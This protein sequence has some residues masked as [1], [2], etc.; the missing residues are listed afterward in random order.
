MS[1]KCIEQII[2]ANLTHIEACIR[3]K[4]WVWV[5]FTAIELFSLIS[6]QCIRKLILCLV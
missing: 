6:F 5:Q 1:K 2:R 4:M 3:K